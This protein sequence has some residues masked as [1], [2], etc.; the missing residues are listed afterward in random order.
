[1]YSSADGQELKKNLPLIID[2]L[3]YPACYIRLQ[4]FSILE[5]SL[6]P[7]RLALTHQQAVD[8]ATQVGAILKVLFQAAKQL[9]G[10]GRDRVLLLRY[11]NLAC[12][13][14]HHAV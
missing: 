10:R 12:P 2:N 13:K 11:E 5:D 3:C 14:I 9:Q 4:P 1:M 6:V 8:V 7:Q